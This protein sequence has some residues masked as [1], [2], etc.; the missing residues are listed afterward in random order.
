MDALPLQDAIEF[1]VPGKPVAWAR[2]H[3]GKIRFT[4][5]LQRR[6]M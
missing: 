3:G 6:V 4:P 5:A 2:T 1:A